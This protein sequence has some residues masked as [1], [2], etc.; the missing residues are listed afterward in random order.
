M[1]TITTKYGTIRISDNGHGVSVSCTKDQARA[2]ATR[3]GAAWPCSDLA[4]SGVIAGF[5]AN[6][7]LVDLSGPE[8]LS[9]REL[10]AW[11]IDVADVA[12]S[13]GYGTEQSYATLRSFRD[14]QAE[15]LR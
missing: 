6:G 5:D 4:T 12:M 2:W 11:A 7:D 14:S 10:T 13:R 3:L 8:D 15:R 1:T 9:G